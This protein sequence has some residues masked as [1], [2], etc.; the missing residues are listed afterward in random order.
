M[1]KILH[2]TLI[3][4]WFDKI[5]SGEKTEEYR[6]YKEYWIKRLSKDFDEI[7]FRN[8]YSKDC[9]FMRVEYKGKRLTQRHGKTVFA[10][11]LGR[12]LEVRL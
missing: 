11:K 4:Q 7:H 10:L 2:L 8:G 1:K 5:A 9:P 12:V 3:K 6:D